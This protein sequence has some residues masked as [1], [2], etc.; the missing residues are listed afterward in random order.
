M[1]GNHSTSSP[2][3]VGSLHVSRQLSLPFVP[4]VLEPDLDLRNVERLVPDWRWYSHWTWVSVR[5]REAARAALSLLER[6]LFRS[7]VDS[8]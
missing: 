7:N 2:T 3:E 5:C 6:Y 4:A 8:N 1:G